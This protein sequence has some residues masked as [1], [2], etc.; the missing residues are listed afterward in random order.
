M[1]RGHRGAASHGRPA[2]GDRRRDGAARRQQL[3]E[4]GRVAVALDDIGFG[5]AADAHGVG[6]ARRELQ[7]RR[8]AGVARR[9]HGGDAGGAQGGKGREHRRRRRVTRHRIGG[10]GAETQ[11]HC[12]DVVRG[13][14]HENAVDRLEDIGE[15]REVV[16]REHLHGDDRRQWSHAVAAGRNPGDVRAVRAA[17]AGCRGPRRRGGQHL[18]GALTRRGASVPGVARFSHDPATERRMRHIDP[19]V[20]NGHGPARA[21]IALRPH[22]VG[23]HQRH[24]LGQ[25]A[26]ERAVLLEGSD[27]RIGQQGLQALGI[28]L[29]DEHGEHRQGAGGTGTHPQPGDDLRQRRAVGRTRRLT[30]HARGRRRGRQA[31]N[32]TNG[33]R[34][35]RLLSPAGQR[36]RTGLIHRLPGRHAGHDRPTGLRPTR[37]GPHECHHQ[38]DTRREP[39]PPGPKPRQGATCLVGSLDRHGQ[40][41][42]PY[43]TP[44][45]FSPGPWA[46]GSEP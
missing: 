30:G 5:G 7:S 4:V 10:L 11:V 27:G 39:S 2:A 34:P 13:G 36:A 32:Q 37:C 1:R 41:T 22:L 12:R 24:T 16:A 17:R 31:G 20:E 38:D 18:A 23:L 6:E 8:R 40:P 44:W 29:D 28:D 26:D 25:R 14:E 19:V 15:I 45:A 43:P 9:D 21:A 46:F 35:L 42:L 3:Q 33:A